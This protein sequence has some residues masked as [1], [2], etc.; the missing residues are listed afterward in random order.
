ML[1]NDVNS[2]WWCSFKVKGLLQQPEHSGIYWFSFT[3]KHVTMTSHK[4]FLS[5]SCLFSNF[6]HSAHT[7]F[8]CFCLFFLHV[9]TC[10]SLTCSHPFSFLLCGCTHSDWQ[11]HI[12][13]GPSCS[14]S[15]SLKLLA[16]SRQTRWWNPPYNVR[17][18]VTPCRVNTRVATCS[19]RCVTILQHWRRQVFFL[20]F[21]LCKSRHSDEIVCG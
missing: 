15:F 9:S 20:T 3:Q 5:L 17:K 19:T 21:H 1:Q 2:G 10:G 7:F 8:F 18:S 12:G 6:L 16:F 11:I 4:L 14:S 13:L